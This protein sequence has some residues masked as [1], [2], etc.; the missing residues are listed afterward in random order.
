MAQKIYLNLQANISQDVATKLITAIEDNLRKGMSELHLL[1]ASPGG[2]VDP[3]MA[4]YNLLRGIPVTVSTYNYGSVDSVAGVI[5]CAGVRRLATPHCKFLI[6]GVT[7]TAPPSPQ[8]ITTTEQQ[9]REQLGQIETVKRN[10]ASVI[11]EATGKTLEQVA[12]DMTSGLTL[13]AEGAKDY[14]L[15]HELTTLL[16]PAGVEVIGI[17]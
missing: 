10:I 3:G 12:A 5:Y 15:V 1:M 6:H 13:T 2:S 4:I 11:A 8:G 9:I 7:W 14:G 16:V 17:R